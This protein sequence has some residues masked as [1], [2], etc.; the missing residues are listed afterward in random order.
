MVGAILFYGGILVAALYFTI[1]EPTGN[2]S[3]KPV[4]ANVE[5]PRPVVKKA[6]QIRVPQGT[7]PDWFCVP[8]IKISP[9]EALIIT[10]LNKFR[11]KWYR[12]VAFTSFPSS[13]WGHYRYDFMIPAKKLIIEYNGKAWHESEEKQAVDRKK[14]AFCKKHGITVI[15]LDKRHY[16]KMPATI[17]RLMGSYSI[18]LV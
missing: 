16:Y 2:K 8:D 7:L 15:T 11:V 1:T 12:E 17:A 10:E 14:V 3:S 18:P 13:K 9:A 6:A 5:M 4:V